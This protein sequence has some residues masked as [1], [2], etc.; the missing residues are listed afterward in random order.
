MLQRASTIFSIEQNMSDEELADEKIKYWV[1]VNGQKY[2]QIEEEIQG[3]FDEFQTFESVRE[4][5]AAAVV[6]AKK[7]ERLEKERARRVSAAKEVR[8]RMSNAGGS[9][10]VDEFTGPDSLA[11]L[12]RLIDAKMDVVHTDLADLVLQECAEIKTGIQS[13]GGGNTLI[14]R[15]S[16]SSI[17]MAGGD[18]HSAIHNM[19]Q[20]E[21]TAELNAKVDMLTTQMASLI[22]KNHEL[23][24]QVR[25]RSGG[26]SSN[27]RYAS[28]V[29]KS[30][31]TSLVSPP[32]QHVR[33]LPSTPTQS[34][35][36]AGSPE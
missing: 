9:G 20:V 5:E 7:A 18:I 22:E 26:S 3:V 12:K 8:E 35:L 29:R 2:L 30:S 10:H 25:G 23:S 36:F 34:A 17:S 6:E 19:S 16:S 15:R 33:A 4:K 27:G 14:R 11:Q 31:S 28:I 24:S 32:A 1:E 13:G 21:K